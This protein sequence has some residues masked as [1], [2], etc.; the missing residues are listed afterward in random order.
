MKAPASV[1]ASVKWRLEFAGDTGSTNDLVLERARAGEEEGLAVWARSQQKGR[2][3]MGRNWYSPP[4]GGLYFSALLRPPAAPDK[5]SL[6]SLL[7]GVAAAETLGE[8]GGR[9]VGLK[10]PND[11]RLGRRKVGGILCEYEPGGGKPG[12]V[13]VGIGINLKT[14]EGG[15]PEN[16]PATSMEEAGCRL[17]GGEEMIGAILQGLGRRYRDFLCQGFEPIR[18]RW[19]GLCDG[20]GDLAEVSLAG[21]PVSGRMRGIDEKGRLVLEQP[22]GGECAVEA[23]EVIE[24]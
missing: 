10:W 15:F 11:L 22:G 2:G 14:P 19:E 24:R 7:A 5:I 6:M 18:K 20:I 13:A 16:I 4:G 8:I 12:A 1:P 23:G 21:E 3:R 17:G 9:P